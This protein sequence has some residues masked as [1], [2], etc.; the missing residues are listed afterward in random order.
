MLKT[1]YKLLSSTLAQRLKPVFDNLLGVEQK[2]YIPGRFISECTRNMY[3]L[4]HSAKQNNLP[5]IILLVDFEKAF[6]SVSFK[7]IMT[8][9]E[10]FEFGGSFKQWIKILLGSVTVVKGTPHLVDIYTDDLTIYLRR[11]RNNKVMDQRN[12]Q[13]AMRVVEVFYK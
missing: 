12:E 7:I 9:L 2:A 5:G 11:E 13:E 6:D 1:L 10:L 4:F 3:D 8:T